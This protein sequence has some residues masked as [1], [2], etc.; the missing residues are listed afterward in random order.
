MRTMW[1][2]GLL[3]AIVT[4]ACAALVACG[5]GDDQSN[6]GEPTTVR[7][8]SADEGAGTD[9]TQGG[10]Q[11][12]AKA[13]TEV[14]GMPAGFPSD[15]PVHPG[16]VTAYVPTEVTESTT[17][18]QLTVESAASFDDVMAWYKTQLPT[19]WSVGFVATEGEKGSREGKIALTGGSYTP[20]SPDG[21]GG[22]V[23]VG[24]F[25]SDTTEIVST[26]TV[27]AP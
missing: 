17:I 19:G 26:V 6:P 11:S 5:G 8:A 1:R 14:S 27:M 18:H 21:K 10:A 22:G 4:L 24:V 2:V 9:S 13:E 20:A 25:E 15:V 23:I 7:N 3:A 16:T 12:G